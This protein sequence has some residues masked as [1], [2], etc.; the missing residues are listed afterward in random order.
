MAFVCGTVHRGEGGPHSFCRQLF[1]APVDELWSAD[2]VQ[3]KTIVLGANNE[4]FPMLDECIEF[5][6]PS[7]TNGGVGTESI[8]VCCGTGIRRSAALVAAYYMH[9]DESGGHSVNEAIERVQQQRPSV[10]IAGGSMEMVGG[11]GEGLIEALKMWEWCLMAKDSAGRQEVHAPE[12]E[13]PLSPKLEDDSSS[14]TG[15]GKRKT[16]ILTGAEG[17]WEENVQTV[18]PGK[19]VRAMVSEIEEFSLADNF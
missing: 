6:G 14:P 16:P 12:G 7:R 13:P 18:S 15:S 2:G 5:M 11:N 8:L 17:R 10:D 1:G 4:L 3:Y 19:K 9:L